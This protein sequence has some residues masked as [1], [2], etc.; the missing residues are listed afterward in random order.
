MLKVGDNHP[1]RFSDSFDFL[2]TDKSEKDC[3]TSRES[4]SCRVRRNLN[5]HELKDQISFVPSGS[6]WTDL[7]GIDSVPTLE[8]NFLSLAGDL[9]QACERGEVSSSDL[10]TEIKVILTLMTKHQPNLKIIHEAFKLLLHFV[11]INPEHNSWLMLL[12]GGVVVVTRSMEA[13]PSECGVQILGCGV[14]HSLST[15]NAH[16]ASP[17]SFHPR[18]ILGNSRRD[19]PPPPILRL[20]PHRSIILGN[21]HRNG[22]FP[23][24]AVPAI[25]TSEHTPPSSNATRLRGIAPSTAAASCGQD[26]GFQTGLPK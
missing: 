1:K 17:R 25:P 3:N 16:K 12:N 23:A 13:H 5:Q 14:L 21:S 2:N 6:A 18:I 7:L 10:S 9:L 15:S 19:G 20:S 26:S 4:R 8:N 22:L 24:L 11:L